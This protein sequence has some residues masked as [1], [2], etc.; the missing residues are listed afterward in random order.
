MI[1]L[2]PQTQECSSTSLGTVGIRKPSSLLCVRAGVNFPTDSLSLRMTGFLGS[3]AILRQLHRWGLPM[4]RYGWTRTWTGSRIAIQAWRHLRGPMMQ[5]LLNSRRM[6][7]SARHNA[8]LAISFVF[9]AVVIKPSMIARPHT[10]APTHVNL[11]MNISVKRRDV[12]LGM[13]L[14]IMRPP[15]LTPFQCWALRAARV[16]PRILWIM[17]LHLHTHF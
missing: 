3:L 13:L 15:L 11:V 12:D 7:T 8:Y 2:M 17:S 5:L 4:S 16:C 14:H 1:W 10:I 6:F 9:R